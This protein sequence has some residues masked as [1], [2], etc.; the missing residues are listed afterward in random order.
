MKT[1]FKAYC[2]S[3]TAMCC[4]E[5]L[6][7]ELGKFDP[8]F[9]HIVLLSAPAAVIVDRIVTRTTNPY[10]KDPAELAL[11]LEHLETVEPLL[12]K[13]RGTRSTPALPLTSGCDCPA[14]R[15]AGDADQKTR[16]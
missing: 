2:L 13:H 9:D 8:Q 14:A 4:S 15:A 10:G 12:K 5:R 6:R 3:K 11:I 16:R 1:A 7:D